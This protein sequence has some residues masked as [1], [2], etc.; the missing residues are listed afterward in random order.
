M[1]NPQ[2]LK[3]A[4][5]KLMST[6]GGAFLVVG[7]PT[8]LRRRKSTDLSCSTFSLALVSSSFGFG[9][10]TGLSSSGGCNQA[11]CCLS[12]A[13]FAFFFFFGNASSCS[14]V[15]VYSGSRFGGGFSFLAQ[16]GFF[17]I[18]AYCSW[19]ES[20]VA[21]SELQMV[22]S[23]SAASIASAVCGA[24]RCKSWHPA[25]PAGQE[26]AVQGEV[27]DLDSQQFAVQQARRRPY[28]MRT[29]IDECEKADY[30]RSND[31]DIHPPPAE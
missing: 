23:F 28:M 8:A 10:K 21:F 29:R 31:C 14:L 7:A 17:P 1:S 4:P 3:N 15:R 13:F 2:L 30:M 5:T 18:F 26:V 19:K 11:G 22:F 20:A 25:S 16:P 27:N 6:P 12:G 9:F 24:S